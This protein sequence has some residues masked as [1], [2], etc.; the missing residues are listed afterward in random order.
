MFRILHPSSLH[1][2]SNRIESEPGP[3]LLVDSFEKSS[4]GSALHEWLALHERW[5]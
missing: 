1:V 4:F 3:G 2:T 5:K